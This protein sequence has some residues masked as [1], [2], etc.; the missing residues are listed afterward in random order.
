MVETAGQRAGNGVESG[1]GGAE[2]DNDPQKGGE[3]LHSEH[4]WLESWVRVVTH[5][6]PRRCIQSAE[7]KAK[8]ALMDE[9]TEKWSELSAEELI[10]KKDA[11]EAEIKAQNEI[12]EGVSEILSWWIAC[13]VM[14]WCAVEAAKVNWYVW[15]SCWRW[16]LP[17]RRCGHLRREES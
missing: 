2:A 9:E 17:Q 1:W 4:R 10:G 8:P 14:M 3:V 11:I 12:L 6:S 16:R 5:T 15:S 13:V 7:G